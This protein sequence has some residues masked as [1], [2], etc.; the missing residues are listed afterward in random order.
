M[1]RV[2]VL[3][4]HPD[5][6]VLGCASVMV[7]HDTLVV[8]VTD[9]VPLNVG[10]K[11]E[12]LAATRRQEA[13]AAHRRLG[14]KVHA[15]ERLGVRDQEVWKQTDEVARASLTFSPVRRSTRCTHRRC[16]P[17]IPTTTASTWPR[18]LHAQRSTT[19]PSHGGASPCTRSTTTESPATAGSIRSCSQR[20]KNAASRPRRRVVRRVRCAPLP[21]S[22]AP[23][24]SCNVGSTIL[25]PSALPRCHRVRRDSPA[26]VV[27]R[28]TIRL[29]RGRHRP[30]HRRSRA[31]RRPGITRRA[32]RW[33]GSRTAEPLPS[34]RCDSC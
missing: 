17:V 26:S 6:E 10:G 24:P 14:A 11:H 21:R 3:A 30:R 5:D 29:H 33:S 12:R 19:P 2:A 7:E 15:I 9:G 28:R 16:R 8:H 34:G 25:S 1:S 23:T 22:S 13:Q 20:S 32:H 31:P 27:L 18:S 4:P